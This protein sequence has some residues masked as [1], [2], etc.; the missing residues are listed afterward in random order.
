MDESDAIDALG[1]LG[2]SSYE[3][4]V[5]VALQKLTV[6]T[7]RDVARIT[8]V[9][10]SQVYGAAERLEERGLIEVQQSSPMQYRPVELGEARAR[11]RR[12]L[13]RERERAFEFLGDVRG[14]YD[15]RDEQQEAIWTVRG[16]EAIDDRANQLV[17][18]AE[19]YVVYGFPA[20]FLDE[21][22]TDALLER[23]A[24]G[25]DV[26]VVS[27]DRAVVE[28]FADTDV[29]A[30]APPEDFT[31][32]EWRGGRIFVA[33]GDTVLMSALGGEK[34]PDGQV[35]IAFWSSGTGFA[36][37]LIQ[38]VDGRIGSFVDL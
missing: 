14:A 21:D 6:G 29:D 1:R 10:R 35:E 25:L 17:R 15:E 4:E 37:A 11:L 3:A 38:L 28:V 24:R 18:A 16:R 13:E 9:P 20:E 22:L 26:T 32:E 12:E 31:Y 7:A 8:D 19:E 5:F 33:D 34:L 27:A 36:T 30:V 2:L 23:A